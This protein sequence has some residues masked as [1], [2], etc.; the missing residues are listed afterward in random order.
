[1]FIEKRNPSAQQQT[2]QKIEISNC[3]KRKPKNEITRKREVL[4]FVVV[5]VDALFMPFLR[6]EYKLVVHEETGNTGSLFHSVQSA[7]ALR[8]IN[9]YSAIASLSKLNYKIC[10]NMNSVR[11]QREHHH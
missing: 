3:F 9:T 4:D 11:Q 5:V 10:K 6:F 7:L 1:M 8:L 2:T